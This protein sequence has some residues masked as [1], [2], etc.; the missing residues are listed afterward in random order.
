MMAAW[1]PWAAF[2]LS[3]ISQFS[4]QYL[5]GAGGEIPW[6]RAFGMGTLQDQ[7]CSHWRQ[8]LAGG[9]LP[10][11]SGSQPWARIPVL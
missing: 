7:W 8:G 11:L 6:P 4:S 9:H 2:L 3:S 1:G 5:A 10:C